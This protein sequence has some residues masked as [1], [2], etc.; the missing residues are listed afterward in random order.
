M[1]IDF[2]ELSGGNYEEHALKHDETKPRDSTK[3]REAFFT[4]VSLEGNI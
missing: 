4:E 2:V 1:K 3:R